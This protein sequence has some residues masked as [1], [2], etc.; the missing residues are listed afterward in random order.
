MVTVPASRIW[1]QPRHGD[2]TTSADGAAAR[3]DEAAARADE[4]VARAGEIVHILSDGLRELSM[5]SHDLEE[6]ARSHGTSTVLGGQGQ[7]MAL[8]QAHGHA[9]FILR[10]LAVLR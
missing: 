10:T 3:A 2:D 9:A 8:D 1:P 5:L 4:A 6:L 7:L